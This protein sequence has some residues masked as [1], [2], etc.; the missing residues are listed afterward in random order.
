[1]LHAAHVGKAHSERLQVLR[2]QL[3]NASNEKR[4]LC[5]ARLELGVIAPELVA[6]VVALVE[7]HLRKPTAA[8]LA[9]DG[10]RR[11]SLMT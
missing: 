10:L 6:H 11:A 7:R 2:L 4:T 1:M 5:A 3:R 9:D 8:E